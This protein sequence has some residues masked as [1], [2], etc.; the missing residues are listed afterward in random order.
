MV[1]TKLEELAQKI[2]KEHSIEMEIMV[3]QGKSTIR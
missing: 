2:S 1:H 3:A